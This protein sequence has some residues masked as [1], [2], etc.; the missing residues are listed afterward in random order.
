MG[1]RTWM[2][3]LA[4]VFR[5]TQSVC[6]TRLNQSICTRQEPFWRLLAAPMEGTMTDARCTRLQQNIDLY[7]KSL[8]KEARA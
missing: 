8:G 3:C 6:M 7:I 2:N 5:M 1:S 4:A